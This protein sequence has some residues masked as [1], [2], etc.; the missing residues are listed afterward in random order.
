VNCLLRGNDD[1]PV[2]MIVLHL[3]TLN[4]TLVSHFVWL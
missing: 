2:E 3:R 4:I 1:S